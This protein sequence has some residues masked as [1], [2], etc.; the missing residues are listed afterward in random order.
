ML[1]FVKFALWN[2]IIWQWVRLT[3]IS[4]AYLVNLFFETGLEALEVSRH[5]LIYDLLSVWTK[6]IKAII[7]FPLH[8]IASNRIVLNRIALHRNRGESYRIASCFICNFNVSYPWL[9]I[10]MRIAS[11]SVMEM[12][13]PSIH[14]S[15][16]HSSVSHAPSHAHISYFYQWWKCR[17]IF[18]WKLIFFSSGFIDE[19]KV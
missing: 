12:H 8:R 4:L 1:I 10:E 15:L 3:E 6:E 11:A 17:L 13:I 14:A 19:Y 16:L 5:R 18:L 9:C 2:Q 7:F